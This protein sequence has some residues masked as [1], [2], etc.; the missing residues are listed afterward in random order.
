MGTENQNRGWIRSTQNGVVLSLHI[1]IEKGGNEQSMSE[2]ENLAQYNGEYYNVLVRDTEMRMILTQKRFECYYNKSQSQNGGIPSCILWCLVYLVSMCVSTNAS[3]TEWL[4][5]A[6]NGD[7]LVAINGECI[8]SYSQEKSVLDWKKRFSV[9][10][11]PR[12]VC[13]FRCQITGTRA[14]TPAKV[15]FNMTVNV[16]SCMGVTLVT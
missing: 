14:F 16:R 4:K 5:V 6:K 1:W 8:A 10:P 3:T 12:L 9:F 15:L 13:F 2:S 7:V 11:Y